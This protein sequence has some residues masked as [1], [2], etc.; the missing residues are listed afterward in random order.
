MNKPARSK[1]HVAL[2]VETATVYGREVLSGIMRFMRTQEDWSVFLEQRDLLTSPPSWLNDWQGDGIISRGS[3]DEMIE[4]AVRRNIPVVELNDRS[5]VDK[6]HVRSDDAKIGEMAAR[7]LMERGFQHFAF[8]GFDFEAWSQRRQEAFVRTIQQEGGQ[9]DA[10]NS[11]WMNLA[12][13]W[14][15]D[16]QAIAEWLQSLPKPCGIFTCNDLRGQHVLA[17]CST[18]ELTVPEEVAVIGVDND[19]LLCQFCQPPLSSVIPN[20]EA[21]GFLAAERLS[22][23]IKGESHHETQQ[24]VAPTGVATR[25]STDVVAIDHPEVASALAYIRQH[26]CEGLTVDEVL[27][28][29]AV[30]R[31][32]LERQL[33]RYLG[34]TPQQEIRN[35]QLKRVRELLVT[36]EMAAEQIAYRAGFDH[37]EYMHYVFKRDL[38]ITPG[39][40]RQSVR[41]QES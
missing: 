37:P 39:Q 36:T 33:R 26:A 9:C 28:N 11:P 41:G 29:V 25:L 13:P 31:S 20:A 40:Y 18:L 21:V 38:G 15:E 2:M 22:R 24:V 4:A 30:S 5:E 14:E 17:V 34:R 32:T 12:R 23:W 35:V 10:F 19:E 8:C 16:Q 6:A 7:H 27:Q 3:T 1:P